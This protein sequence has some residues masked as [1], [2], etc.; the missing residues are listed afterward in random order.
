MK[1]RKVNGPGMLNVYKLGMVGKRLKEVCGTDTAC[2]KNKVQE[3]A[4]YKFPEDTQ[5]LQL[6]DLAFPECSANRCLERRDSCK[7]AGKIF[8]RLRRA[9]FLNPSKKEYWR[10]LSCIYAS[11]G[12]ADSAKGM[13]NIYK[14]SLRSGSI[15]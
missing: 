9:A 7:D 5:I 2:F 6:V 13:I 15:R 1:S 14:R 12:F 10:A 3:D 8:D 11:A 4:T